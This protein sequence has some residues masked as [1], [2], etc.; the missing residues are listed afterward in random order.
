MTA[1]IVNL[2]EVVEVNNAQRKAAV[3]AQGPGV[4]GVYHL[5]KDTP[6]PYAGERV[7]FTIFAGLL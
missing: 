7:D 2:F 4:L 3:V 1:R 5:L 6:R